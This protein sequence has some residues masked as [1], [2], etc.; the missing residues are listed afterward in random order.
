MLYKGEQS[1]CAVQFSPFVQG[2]I[3]VATSQNFGIVGN[4]QVVIL[5]ASGAN[6]ARVHAYD[7][8]DATLD[9]AWCEDNE[10]IVASACGDGSIKIWDLQ[11]PPNMNPIRS[12]KEH[13]NEVPCVD[14]NTS[15]RDQFL[16][17]SWDDTVKLW[18]LNS[19][20]S[21]RTFQRHT[22]CVYTAKWN[23]QHSDVF[24]STSGDS[25]AMI[26]DTRKPAPA[27]ILKAHAREILSGDWCKYNDCVIATASID[28]TIK[29][30]DVRSP[31]APLT[32]L[33]GHTYP[34][35]KVV[36]SPHAETLLASCSY[37]MTVRLWDVAAPEDALLNVWDHHSEFA[38]GLDWDVLT[39]GMLASGS[40][41]TCV[42]TW[43]RNSD[44]RAV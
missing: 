6:L 34:V 5:Q 23:P 39:E 42:H 2:R 32:T 41:D 7:T 28:K 30:W 9:V 1:V 37:D 40:W 12:L 26:W 4:G 17:S 44:P 8:L 22:Y 10:N 36:F 43:H 29:V 31:N 15:R 13:Q 35:R 38:V 33:L 25:T 3:A 24:L 11:A 18:T 21:I 27:L 14:W 16:T 20:T 19:P